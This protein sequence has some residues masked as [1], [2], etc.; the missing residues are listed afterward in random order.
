MRQQY[1]LLYEKK[2]ALLFYKHFFLLIIV[3]DFIV[4]Q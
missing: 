2:I 1:V 4:S 3:Q